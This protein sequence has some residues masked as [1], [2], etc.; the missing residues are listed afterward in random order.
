MFCKADTKPCHPLEI[1]TNGLQASDI[2]ELLTF[3]ST[4]TNS[5]ATGSVNKG[6]ADGVNKTGEPRS[7]SPKNS[8]PP[9]LQQHHQLRN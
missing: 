4:G 5:L 8:S 1:S 7:E 9:S 6:N 2:K 3:I